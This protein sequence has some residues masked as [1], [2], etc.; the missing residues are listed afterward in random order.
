MAQYDGLAVI[1]L[2]R[3]CADYFTHLTPDKMKLKVAAGEIDLPL[4][5][6]EGSQKSARGVHLVDLAQYIDIRA[7]EARSELRR[8][9]GGRRR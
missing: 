6:I 4:I 3:V 5:R 2:E 1:P 8:L 7:N 9:M